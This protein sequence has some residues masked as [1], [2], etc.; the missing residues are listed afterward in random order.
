MCICDHPSRF[1][2]IGSDIAIGD[3]R[4]SLFDDYT[5]EAGNMVDYK[6][7]SVTYF[8]DGSRPVTMLFPASHCPM[9]GKEL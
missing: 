3:W 8:E 4:L 1:D 6:G 2:R 5:E 7:I 9:C